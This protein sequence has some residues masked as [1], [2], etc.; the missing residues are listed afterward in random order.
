MNPANN[1]IIRQDG[2]TVSIQGNFQGNIS[3][4][5]DGSITIQMT[6]NKPGRPTITATQHNRHKRV[7]AGQGNRGSRGNLQV[8]ECVTA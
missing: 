7:R 2:G 8:P 5:P 3:Q 4:T 6:N 1:L